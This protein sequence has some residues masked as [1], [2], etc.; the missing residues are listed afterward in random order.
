MAAAWIL[1]LLSDV[2]IGILNNNAIWPRM[3]TIPVQLLMPTS[4][5]SEKTMVQLNGFRRCATIHARTLKGK[6]KGGKIGGRWERKQE[7]INGKN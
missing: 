3:A 4:G 7:K 1:L 6:L 2:A 5:W